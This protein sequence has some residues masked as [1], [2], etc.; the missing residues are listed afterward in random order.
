M[1]AYEKALAGVPTDPYKVGYLPYTI[2]DGWEALRE[3][4]AYFRVFDYLAMHGGP[5]RA[6]WTADRSLR[7]E[8]IV[9]DIGVWGHFVGDGSQPLHVTTHYND[10][11]IHARFEGEFVRNNVTTQ[12]VERL[13]PPGGPRSEDRAIDQR[14]LMAQIG[15]YLTASNAEVP[16]L[17]AIE[18]RGGFRKDSPEAVAFA[19]ARVADGARELRDLIVEAYDNSLYSSVGYPEMSVQ[20]VLGGRVSPLPNAFGGD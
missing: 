3:D 10:R 5:Y 4:F 2:A 13:V 19:T 1:E 11:G 15:E 16:Q 18:R 7:E 6:A 20:D 9:H 17:Y 12:A 14:E 8:L